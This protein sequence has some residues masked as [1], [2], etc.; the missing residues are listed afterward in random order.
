M[1]HVGIPW[2]GTWQIPV[3]WSMGTD[4][5]LEQSL[6][7]NPQCSLLSYFPVCGFRKPSSI[8]PLQLLS[9]PSQISTLK[10]STL[11]SDHKYRAP[12][13]RHSW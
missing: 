5:Y 11:Q 8:C 12:L 9:R 10:S 13:C 7:Q 1:T 4:Q 6:L 2:A 3:V